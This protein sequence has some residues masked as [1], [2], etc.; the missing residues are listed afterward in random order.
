MIRLTFDQKEELGYNTVRSWLQPAS[1]YGAARLKEEG[2]YGPDRREALEQ[3]FD[4]V[5][6]LLE[7]LA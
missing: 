6:V 2:F 1:P 7:A 3:E 5:A 4:N